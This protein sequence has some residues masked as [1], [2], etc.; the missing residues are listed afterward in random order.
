MV[1][2][3]GCSEGAGAPCVAVGNDSLLG[4]AAAAVGVVEPEG[5][6]SGVYD[7]P[8]A[9]LSVE[10]TGEAYPTVWLLRKVGSGC[11]IG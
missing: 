3:G 8:A 5:C 9:P 7:T 10:V 11:T 2:C 4:K 1:G 6:W